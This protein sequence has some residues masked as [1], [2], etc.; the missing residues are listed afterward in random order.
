MTMPSVVGNASHIH[1]LQVKAEKKHAQ[2]FRPETQWQGGVGELEGWEGWNGVKLGLINV[3]AKCTPIL[4]LP[5]ALHCEAHQYHEKEMDDS[6]AEGE[7]RI[8]N[9][10]IKSQVEGLNFKPTWYGISS[11]HGL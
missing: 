9:E 8:E 6:W 2:S 1:Q 7:H 5:E 11:N 3:R 4:I 10:E